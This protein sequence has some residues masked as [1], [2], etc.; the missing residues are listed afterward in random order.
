MSVDAATVRRIAHL[1]R[2]A[3]AEEEIDP[4]SRTRIGRP[5]YPLDDLGEGVYGFAGGLL[6]SHRADFPRSGVARVG[7]V[8]LP[9]A[10][11]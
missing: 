6:M 1:A 4:L 11:G 3:V 2:I 9:R 8:A 5:P 10:G 7:W